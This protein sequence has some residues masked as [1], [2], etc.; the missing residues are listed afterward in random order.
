M[1]YLDIYI[2]LFVS[3]AARLVAHTAFVNVSQCLTLAI[4]HG[5]EHKAKQQEITSH[6]IWTYI[7][8]RYAFDQMLP[9]TVFFICPTEFDRYLR[10][11]LSIDR[12]WVCV[13]NSR[14]NSHVLL[15]HK[16]LLCI[17]VYDV[18]LLRL[19]FWQGDLTGGTHVVSFRSKE[20][21]RLNAHR[22]EPYYF[23]LGIGENCQSISINTYTLA[24]G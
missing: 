10:T 18:C 12:V 22:R 15:L 16:M 4:A 8:Y 23:Q 19:V 3:L 11:F 7:K 6:R 14:G 21:R 24:T 13:R 9:S 17:R 20:Q 1:S 2:Y 5:Y